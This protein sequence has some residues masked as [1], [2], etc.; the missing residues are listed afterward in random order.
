MPIVL[1]KALP[2]AAVLLAASHPAWAGETADIAK[3]FSL[4][5]PIVETVLQNVDS[6]FD[7][8][9][10]PDNR[11]TIGVIKELSLKTLKGHIN[12]LD[13]EGPG[14][15]TENS[16]ERENAT[17]KVAFRTTRHEATESAECVEAAAK[18][19]SVEGTS[20]VRDGAFTF[21]MVHPKTSTY[22]WKMTFCRTPIN[23][24]SDFSDWQMK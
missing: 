8:S 18:I 2:V 23:G 17:Y 9:D 5:V 4:P 24:G 20:V 21:D 1:K 13:E 6:Y 7:S 16:T 11:L 15:V 19:T 10:A 3:R 22:S 12:H 14:R